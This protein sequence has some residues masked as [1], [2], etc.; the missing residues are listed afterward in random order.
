V[1]SLVNATALHSVYKFNKLT[2][3]YLPLRAEN[4]ILEVPDDDSEE[5]KPQAQ[6]LNN[7]A[8][9]TNEEE[10]REPPPE[11]KDATVSGEEVN[12]RRPLNL[13]W[14]GWRMALEMSFLPHR[15]AGTRSGHSSCIC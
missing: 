12:R 10:A 13:N 6:P 15:L 5:E 1:S 2:A 11:P 4:A 7:A 14:P 8:E 9:P 3:Q